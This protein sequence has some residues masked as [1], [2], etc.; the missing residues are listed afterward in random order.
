[1]CQSDS[2]NQI[3]RNKKGV[4]STTINAA[5][6]KYNSSE[7]CIIT[8]GDSITNGQIVRTVQFGTSYEEGS[9]D[10]GAAL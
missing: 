10:G 5:D 4:G 8:P 9:K 2:F 6:T 3:A 1:M 7:E